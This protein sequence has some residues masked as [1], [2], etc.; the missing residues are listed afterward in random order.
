MNYPFKHKKLE[1]I[2]RTQKDILDALLI[3]HQTTGLMIDKVEV[4]C[5]NGLI[6]NVK[7]IERRQQ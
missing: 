1:R 2:E 5:K 4:E 3:L 7:I 6:E